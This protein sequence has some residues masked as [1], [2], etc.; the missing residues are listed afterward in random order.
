MYRSS[1]VPLLILLILW[2][3]STGYWTVAST[4]GVFLSKKLAEKLVGGG[5]DSVLHGKTGEEHFGSIPPIGSML[6]CQSV[7]NALTCGYSLF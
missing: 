1:L 2:I 5:V 3:V 4:N 7:N 6:V